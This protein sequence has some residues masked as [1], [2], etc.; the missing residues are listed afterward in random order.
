MD[1]MAE[2]MR[3]HSPYNY[4]FNNPLRFIDPDGMAPDVAI[5]QGAPKHSDSEDPT[6]NEVGTGQVVKGG[7]GEVIDIG[8]VWSHTEDGGYLSDLKGKNNDNQ[9]KSDCCQ[10]G[11]PDLLGY[12]NFY[13]NQMGTDA[14]KDMFERYWLGKGDMVL[15]KKQFNEIVKLAKL[16][17]ADD[18]I[19]TST[20]LNGQEVIAKVISFYGTEHGNS[21]G[22][23]TIY[24]NTKGVAVGFYDKFD[25][26]PKPLGVRSFEAE[27]KTRL[28]NLDGK[29]VGA[30]PFK[31]TYP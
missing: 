9:E 20:N 3:R 23:A 31:I 4:A 6:Q 13:R 27:V 30:K 26:D 14:G 16:Q 22:R 15:T 24:Y 29:A 7:Y 17:G 5:V 18:I 25:F 2:K 28:V 19:G 1:P 10:D 21:L 8:N 12:G 11:R